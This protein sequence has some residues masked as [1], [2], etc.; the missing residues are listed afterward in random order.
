MSMCFISVREVELVFFSVFV[1][2]LS[3]SMCCLGFGTVE[4]LLFLLTC[5]DGCLF[6]DADNKELFYF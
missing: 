2:V 3:L 4:T 5:P 1:Y 6:K